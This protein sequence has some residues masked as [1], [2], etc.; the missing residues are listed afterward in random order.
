[1]QKFSLPLRFTDFYPLFV[2]TILPRARVLP[3]FKE[4]FNFQTKN[5]REKYTFLQK[6]NTH[7]VF[8]KGK[9]AFEPQKSSNYFDNLDI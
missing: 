6:N 9:K 5:F 8:P 1:M 7:F 4:I 3:L 2:N